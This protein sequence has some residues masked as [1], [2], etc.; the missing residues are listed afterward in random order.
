MRHSHPRTTIGRQISGCTRNSQKEGPGAANSRAH[1]SGKSDSVSQ[2]NA[3]KPYALASITKSGL[4]L[5][6]MAA[7]LS[8]ASEHWT[9]ENAGPRT[10][11]YHA[12]IEEEFL[13]NVNHLLSPIIHECDPNWK[14]M[15]H[16]S[17]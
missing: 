15:L 16:H 5:S 10:S 4:V 13:P 3:S 2:W 11:G 8:L 12:A 17:A 1:A 7:R 9:R 14:L 6:T